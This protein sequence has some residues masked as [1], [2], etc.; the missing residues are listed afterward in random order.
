MTKATASGE[1]NELPQLLE[2]FTFHDLRAKS[3]SDD[4]LG[5][6]TERLAHDDPRTTQKIYRRKPRRARA[7][8][9]ILDRNIDIGR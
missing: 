1:Q 4:E 2:R 6:A 3:A 8:A 9:K 7:G 5:A